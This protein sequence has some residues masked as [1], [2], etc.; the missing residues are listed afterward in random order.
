VILSL[1]HSVQILLFNR[2]T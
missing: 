1:N 2:S